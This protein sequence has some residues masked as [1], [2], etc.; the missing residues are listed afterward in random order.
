MPTVAS[1]AQHRVSFV[2]TTE[3]LRRNNLSNILGLLHRGGPL[4]RAQLTRL[5]GLN[6]STVGAVV[7]DLADLRLVCERRSHGGAKA[8]RPSPVVHIDNRTAAIAVN[9]RSMPSTLG[10]SAL[11]ATFSDMCELRRHGLPAPKRW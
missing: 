11:A 4:S 6:R 2:G 3:E 9:P 7:T 1:P 8:G 10:W 5:T